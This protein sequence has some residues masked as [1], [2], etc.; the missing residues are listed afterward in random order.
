[1]SNPVSSR[2]SE[3]CRM[4]AVDDGAPWNYGLGSSE[5]RVAERR[6]ELCDCLLDVAAA[7]FNVSG[8]DLRK[9]G[10]S[11]AEVSRVRQIAM[12]TAHVV[13][14]ISMTDVGTGFGRDRTTV[15]HACH[16]IEDMR[17]DEDFDA[18]VS[19][20]ERVAGAAFRYRESGGQ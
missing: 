5:N 9:P 12:Y 3:R 2:S 15:M 14:G 20:F 17:D 19:A 8:R 6:A 13:M 16:V 10:R 18:V 7:M 1:M 4:P 11:T